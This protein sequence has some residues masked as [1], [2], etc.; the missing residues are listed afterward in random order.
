[1]G[2]A[3][4]LANLIVECA[5]HIVDTVNIRSKVSQGAAAQ[6]STGEQLKHIWKQEGVFGFGRGFSA[7]FYGAIFQ[8]FMYFFLYKFIKLSLH[9]MY[10]VDINPTIVFIIASIMA[11]SL[12]L[13]VHFPYDL[14]KCR[15][16]AKNN[17]YKY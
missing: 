9:E 17:I 12:T 10:G 2:M 5:F 4:S 16:Q 3:G 1:M 6:R 8:G 14:I 11:E 15:L 13:S 7:C